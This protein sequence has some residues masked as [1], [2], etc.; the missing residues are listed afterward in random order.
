MTNLNEIVVESPRISS[1][2]KVI[3][4]D[5]FPKSLYEYYTNGYKVSDIEIKMDLF[6]ALLLRK[7]IT[8]MLLILLM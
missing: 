6:I 2:D 7:S 4:K 1:K 5:K 3:Y 8:M